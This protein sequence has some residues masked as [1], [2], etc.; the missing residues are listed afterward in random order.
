MAQSPEQAAAVAKYKALLHSLFEPTERQE[1]QA[2]LQNFIQ[3]R[4]KEKNQKL[5]PKKKK[6][7]ARTA[8]TRKARTTKKRKESE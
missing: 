4:H 8:E 1:L 2:I 3:G 6:L 7:E 5:E